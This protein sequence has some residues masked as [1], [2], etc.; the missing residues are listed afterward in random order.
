MRRVPKGTFEGLSSFEALWSAWQACRRGKRRWPTLAAFDLDAD[1]TL[2]RLHRALAEDRYAPSPYRISLVRDPKI[3]LVAAPAVVDRV[4]Q[5]AL[6]DCIG[7]V[8]ERSFIDQSY[9]VGS[10][11]GPHRAALAFLAGMRRYPLRMHLDVRHYFASI[12]HGVLLGLFGLRLRDRRTLALIEQLL[13]AGGAVYRHPL[14]RVA[15]GAGHPPA[16]GRGLP[17]GG[18]LSHWSGGFYMDGLDHFIKRELKIPGYLRYM[19]DFV[20]FGEREAVLC[21]AAERIG[22]WLT[23]QRRLVLKEPDARPVSNRRPAVFLGFR[24]SRAGIGAGPKA[25]ARLRRRLRRL[26]SG[27]SEHLARSLQSYRGMWR[28]LGG[29]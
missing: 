1:L 2:L 3:R 26:A 10:G 18:Y 14:A 15:L 28:A 23:S 8:Y 20:L 17:L 19:D 27:D 5:R 21:E 22:D 13:D 29:K 7:P 12:D 9:A 6:I 11:R 25:R 4:V 16:E 24:L